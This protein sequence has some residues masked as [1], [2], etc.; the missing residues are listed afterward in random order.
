MIHYEG[1]PEIQ[2]KILWRQ[3]GFIDLYSCNPV[4]PCF[5]YL[6]LRESFSQ[7]LSTCPQNPGVT[8]RI[9]HVM[10]H[11]LP[12]V[13]RGISVLLQNRSINERCICLSLETQ[14]VCYPLI[15]NQH[16]SI[17]LSQSSTRNNLAILLIASSKKENGKGRNKH[18]I[19]QQKSHYLKVAPNSFWN[20]ESNLLITLSTSLSVSVFSRS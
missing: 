14:V 3:I 7:N 5:L 12:V 6:E 15:Y 16:L 20:V 1:I 11:T 9:M 8:L 17:Y 2:G 13:I 18:D 19:S 4:K 10:V